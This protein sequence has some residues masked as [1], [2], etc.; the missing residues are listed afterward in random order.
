MMDFWVLG[1]GLGRKFF[2]RV[3]AGVICICDACNFDVAGS[4]DPPGVLCTASN[5]AATSLQS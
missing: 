2:A 1:G 5:S 4:G 3:L